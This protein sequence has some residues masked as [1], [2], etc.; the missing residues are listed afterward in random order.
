M[1][2][3]KTLSSCKIFNYSC[4]SLPFIQR[5]MNSLCQSAWENHGDSW[6]TSTKTGFNREKKPFLRVH[7]SGNCCNRLK[8]E[9]ILELKAQNI[10]YRQLHWSYT[11]SL[12]VFL[13]VHFTLFIFCALQCKTTQNIVWSVFPIWL[14]SHCLVHLLFGNV[15]TY[16]G[17][18]FKW[19]NYGEWAI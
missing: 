8:P 3:L 13:K 11:D 10:S 17:A 12:V 6:L 7:V 14:W 9:Y 4:K 16:Q 18:M 15:V 19:H 2:W 1:K 5:W